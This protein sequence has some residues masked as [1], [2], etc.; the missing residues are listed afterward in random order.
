MHRGSSPRASSDRDRSSRS[1]S[2]PRRF[3]VFSLTPVHAAAGAEHA[4]D[5]GALGAAEARVA[6]GD[7]VRGDAALAVRRP[8]QRDETRLA[9]D[10]VLHFDRVADRE[11]VRVRW[12]ASARRRGC[13]RARRSRA[14]PISPARCPG[15]RRARGSRRRPDAP[16]RT[17]V[18]TFNAPPSAFSKAATP[19][20]R[21][22]LTP[23]RSRWPSTTRAI[24]TSSG[25]R[26]WSAI[27]TRV[28]SNPR[29]IRF[30]AVSTPMKP[31]PTTTARVLG[32]IVWNPE[33]R[34]MPAR[35]SEPFSSHSRI[36]RASGTV[37]SWKI[38]GRSIPGKGGRIDLAPGD[39]TSLSYDS[40]VTLP[41][42]TSRS[43][44]VL[45]SGR[46]SRPR[47]RFL[48]RSRRIRGTSP[49]WRRAG[50]IPSRSRRRRGTAARSSRTKRRGRVRRSRSRRSRPAC[51]AARHTTRHRPHRRRSRLSCLSSSPCSTSLV[52]PGI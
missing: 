27:S 51:A 40:V 26:I 9:G 38:P 22:S 29:W 4:D 45:V 8:G 13:R 16:C 52:H 44:S 11:D 21:A 33:Y 18:R 31:P 12:S 46:S 25:A 2:S 34:Y 14:R 47:S 24:S 6:A 23:W 19:S 48:P 1:R 37:R 7:R 39:N 10:G 28:T 35:N 42:A 5:R 20:L 15:A 43:S 49:G 50:S 36:A 32:R 30:S 3:S 17:S 41:V